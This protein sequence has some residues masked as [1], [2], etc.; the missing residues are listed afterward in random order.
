M[1]Q[2][3]RRFVDVPVRD[4]RLRISGAAL[5]AFAVAV[6]LVWRLVPPP[7]PQVVRLG[8]GPVGGH[9]AHFAAAL[10]RQVAETGFDL[11]P[12]ATAGSMENIRLLLSGEIDVGLVQS[13]NLTDAEAA[14]LESIAA[15]LY[16]PVL[17]VERTDWDSTHIA[18]GRIGIGV[19][20][21]G[22]HAL[23]RELLRDQ[24]VWDD[25]PPGTR[26]VE[27]GQERAAEALRAG[28]LD[29]AVFVTSLAVPWVHGLFADP[30]LRVTDFA[31]AEAF[32]R[33]YR[34]LERITIPAGL[35]DLR[36]KIPPRDVSVIATTAS[37]VIRPGAHRALVPLLIESAREQLSQG[38]LLAAPGEFPS[39]H[40]VEAPLADEALQYFERGP[41]FFYRWL[42][43]RYAFAATRLTI[44]LLPLLTLLYPLFRSI[45]PAYR[46][47]I[48]RRVY[49]WYRVLR[50]L[51]AQIDA[52]DHSIASLEEIRTEL[53]QVA[54]EIRGTHVPDSYGAN[55]FALRSHH[56]LL[57]ERLASIEASSPTT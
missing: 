45:E 50:K 28:E 25:H 40:G 37:L 23:V 15:V 9:Y 17:V 55:L 11:E 53:E 19:P 5:L 35:L 20:G 2:A 51:E 56:K 1:S 57:V 13:G 26:L 41:S 49:R 36:K 12:V 46:W 8:T 29:S 7:L 43:F 14:Q 44:V 21:S 22:V 4:V 33:H 30:E 47:V 10:R 52:S 3:R 38:S 24:G 39:A 31:L 27:V 34:Y 54:E 18:G 6:I 16:E 42:P 32:A 48:Q